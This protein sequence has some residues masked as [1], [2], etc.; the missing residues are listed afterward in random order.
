MMLGYERADG[1]KG[2]RNYVLVAYL[3]ECAHH[4]AR[5]IA[6]PF[7]EE[8]V[9][10]I[11]FPGCYPNAYAQRMME[12]FCTHPNVGAVL[13]VSLGCEEFNRP[14]L[15][16]IIDASGRP[17][18]AAGDPED[19]RHALH[20][21]D[22]P[23]MGARALWS[24]S[25]PFRACRSRSATWWSR[26]SA[27][28]RTATSGSPPTRRSAIAC[29]HVIEAAA[30]RSSRR[31]GEL[32]GCE[33]H[34][35][36]PRR[37]ARRS[38]TRSCGRCK[39]RRATTPTLEQAASAAATSPAASRRSRRNRSAPTPRAARKP[40]AGLLKPGVLPP[41]RGLYLMDM[42]PDDEAKLGLPQHQRQRHDRS[43]R[44]PAARTSCCSRPAA[45]R[46]S[47]RRSRR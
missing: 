39:G 34:M 15:K 27:A 28:A 11:G 22:R 9:Q 14:R 42:V 21:P 46:W 7:E 5:A 36:R 12:A 10:L 20:H 2:I 35:A 31:L 47:A 4:V 16:E 23:R 37:S 40:I 26:P 18:R 41:R 3:V 8:G 43:S 13:V 33:Q 19:R 24:R 45:A 29:D 44:S 1:R 30:P 32:F 38:A 25:R 17:C 6:A